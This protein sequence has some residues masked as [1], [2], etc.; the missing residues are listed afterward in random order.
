MSSPAASK[1]HGSVAAGYEQVAAAFEQNFAQRGEIGAAFAAYVN[2]EPVVDLWGGTADR[3]SDRAWDQDTLVGIFS[4]SKGIVAICMLLLIER[5]QIDLHAPVCDYWPEFAAVGK[6]GILVRD[7]LCHEA[8]LPGLLTPV[9]IE[10]ATDDL[11]MAK[12]LAAQ[13]PIAEPASGPR[14]HA[15]T[16]GWLCG[17]LLRRIDGRSIGTFLREEIAQPLGLDVWIGLPHAYEP[18]VAFLERD[19]AFAKEQSNVVLT[20][21]SDEVAWSIWSNPPRFAEGELAGNMPIWH[22]A[23][24]PATNGIVSARSLAR[25]YGCLALGGELDGVRLLRPETIQEAQRCLA[26]GMDPILDELLAFG[27]G[28]ELQTEEQRFG[29]AASAFGHTGAGGSVHGAWPR[30]RTGFSYT[31]NLLA[32]LEAIDPRAQALLRALHSAVATAQPEAGPT[33]QASA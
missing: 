8:G 3:R 14:Y 5:G 9:N 4:G 31:P 19:A 17:E 15:V 26:R 7:V 33:I 6:Q 21:E 24:I 1:I 32:S 28:F 22:Q 13:R 18:R 25:L 16:F 12:L 30:M 20:R 29:P 10:E 2:G 11:R 23:E 27:T